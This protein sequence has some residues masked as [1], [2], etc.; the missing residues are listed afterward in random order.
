MERRN[1][2]KRVS[3]GTAGAIILPTIIP[4]SVM[5]KNA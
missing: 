4:S 2:L 5:G 3:A 1:F